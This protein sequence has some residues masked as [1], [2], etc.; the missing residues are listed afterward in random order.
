MTSA[1]AG[2]VLQHIRR[3][4]GACPAG[5]PPDA[6]LLE[7]FTARRD[8]AAFAALVR[9]HGPMVLNVCRSILRHEQDA[10]DAFQATFLVLAR[11]AGAIRQPEAVAGWL[12]EVAHRAAVKAQADAARR[13]TLE[14]RATPVAPADPTLD[15]TLRDLRRVLH[16]ELRRLPEKYRLPLVLCYLEGRSREDA[17]GQLGWS[18][19]T[20]CGRLDRGREHLRRRLA[21]RGVALSALLCAAA[22]APRA[23]AEALVDSVV[24]CAVNGAAAGALS[25]RAAALAEGVTRAMGIGKLKV[26]TALLLAAGLVLTGAG[27]LAHQARAARER[28]A[29][30]P[31]PE[32][33]SPKPHPA[34]AAA[35]PAGEKGDSVPVSGRV[36]DPEGKPV[37]GAKVFFARYI[38]GLRNLPPVAITSDA[39]GRFRLDVSRTGYQEDYEKNLWLRGAVVAVRRGFAPGWVGADSADKLANVTIKLGKDVPIKGRV[40]DLQGKPVAGVRVQVRS[41]AFCEDG[42]SLK[43]F[44]K[45]LRSRQVRFGWWNHPACP[46]MRLDPRPLG[47]TPVARTGADGTF[48]LTGISAE[49]LVLLRF[50]GPTIETSEEYARTRPGPTIRLTA[51]KEL[52]GSH[53]EV[54]HGATFDHAAAP[55]RPIVGIVRDRDTGKPLAGVTIHN[56]TYRGPGKGIDLQATTDKEGRYRLVGLSRA[57]GHSLLAVPSPGQPYLRAALL[58]PAATGLDPVTV[59]FTLKRGV[60]IRGRVTDKGTGRP[61]AALVTYFAFDGNPYLREA[62]GYRDSHSIDVRT[63]KDGTFTVLGLPGRG[64]VAAK[65]ANR[66]REGHY[67]MAVGADG[68]KGRRKDGNFITHPNICD[69]PHYNTL[70]EVNPA[71]D[72]RSMTR[73]LV[74][75]PG[76]TVTGTIVD[77]D[78]KPVKGAT[79]DSMFG[80]WLLVN[81]LATAQFRISGIDAKHPRSFFF[82][83][84]GRNLGAAVLFTGDEPMPVTVRLRKCA[85]VTGRLVDE[86]GL[87]V[88]AW[89][90]AYIHKGQLNSTRM[91]GRASLMQVTGK[92]GRFRLEGI[93]PGLKIGIMAGKNITYYD[94]NLVPEL[95]LRPGEVRDL[96]DLKRKATE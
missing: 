10:E 94:Q 57:A 44:V 50:Q 34:A 6:Q 11:K 8:E 45:A 30:S 80:V 15:M 62:P 18:K 25:A 22:V 65:T 20:L 72:A 12:Y 27:V 16:E 46:R 53:P 2:L 49:C 68:I 56:E 26:I 9:R 54:F 32:G 87:P 96:G 81:D 41:V 19:G 92:D 95:T 76:K 66:E 88:A 24:P 39:K 93:I 17:A 42:A 63:A 67:L 70:V 3:L 21:A 36:V 74:L 28:P 71:R 35:R 1:Q 83:H 90:S 79:I 73:D 52:L 13:R 43:D 86:D 89:I 23:A 82:L 31:K 85:T 55:T 14:R 40:V 78:G 51:D 75:D 59:D 58:S 7:R 5:Q 33:G 48:R 69:A 61:V 91:V 29:G 84:P 37:A 4:A 60:V 47:L 77:P 64:L 38:L